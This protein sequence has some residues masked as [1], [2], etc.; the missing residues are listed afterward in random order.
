MEAPMQRWNE[1]VEAANYAF[2]RGAFSEAV[3][4]YSGAAAMAG[5]FHAVIPAAERAKLYANRSFA[6][7]K[8]GDYVRACKDAET[9][10]MTDPTFIKGWFRLGTALNSLRLP[11]EAVVAFRTA[12]VLEPQNA[13]VQ[14]SLAGAKQQQQQARGI[15]L[16]PHLRH[17][18]A[19]VAAAERARGTALY[20]AADWKGA[21][22]AYA[23]AAELAPRVAAYPA[24]V[25]AAALMLG[26]FR[27]AA[28]R[29]AQAAE[30]DPGFVRAH[31]R[32]GKACL[33]MGKYEQASAHYARAV[34]LDSGNAALRSEAAAVT[35]VRSH[36]EQGTALLDSDART[37]QWH[38]DCAAR[39][40]QPPPEPAQ[41]LRVQALLAQSRFA[42]AVAEG[43]ELR[44]EGDTSAPEVLALRASALYGCGN[45]DL[46]MRC[47]VEAL[48]RDPDC[49]AAARG[50][51]RLRALTAAKEAGNAA[52]K[53]GAWAEAHAQYSAALA[54]N[55]PGSG[56]SAFMAQC[57]CNRA[58]TCMKLGRHADALADAEAAVAADAGYA[59]GY[60]RRALAHQAIGGLDSLE[61]AVRDFER[62]KQMEP[63]MPDIG[64]LLRE[65]STALKKAKRVDYYALL[66]VDACANEAEI[67]KAYKRVALKYHPDKVPSEERNEAERKFKQVGAAVAILSD[68][69]KRQRYD[70]GWSEEEIEQGCQAGC[71]GFRGTHSEHMEDLLASMFG[72]GMG[73]G[74][75]FPGGGF[76]SGG[77]PG[78]RGGFGGRARG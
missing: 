2:K 29:A 17:L 3:E 35:T 25:A 6:Y 55:S 59:K 63:E 12:A 62:V 72:G 8:T 49:A 52:F 40:C 45:L 9:A 68:A 26:Q 10:V 16:P 19:D 31:A 73:G 44:R 13:D 71:G 64:G 27:V 28:E 50:L 76:P 47:Y 22:A 78:G 61:E 23:A 60:L 51:K 57:A 21:F 53:A 42:E 1:W 14:N 67:K 33:C 39:A 38:G 58:A 75:G 69:S 65:A 48:R 70:A 74:G 18:R 15:A 77:F 41:L 11:D 34:E 37:A 5:D 66:E 30:L 24:N 32:A 43:R 36:V 56:N 46:A 7:H 20:K 4:L 54:H